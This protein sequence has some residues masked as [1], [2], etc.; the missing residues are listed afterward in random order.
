M[1]IAIKVIANFAHTYSILLAYNNK[2][3]AFY[4]AVYNR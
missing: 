1:L 4:Y 3:I 2:S